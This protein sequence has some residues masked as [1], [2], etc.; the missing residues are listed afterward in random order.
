MQTYRFYRQLKTN[1]QLYNYLDKT[2]I[3]ILVIN[4]HIILLKVAIHFTVIK[5]KF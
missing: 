2:W 1:S 3:N 5:Y 4:A